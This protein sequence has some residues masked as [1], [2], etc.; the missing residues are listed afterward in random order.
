VI[1]FIGCTDLGNICFDIDLASNNK[2]TNKEL[3]NLATN[4]RSLSLTYN[5]L[6]TDEVVRQFTNLTVLNLETNG[7][8]TDNSISVLTNLTILN[9]GNNC[10]FYFLKFILN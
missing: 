7:I 5:Q 10:Y 4:L 6:I 8:I 2:I 1:K 3:V 9:V